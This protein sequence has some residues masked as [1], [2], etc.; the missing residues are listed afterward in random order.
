MTTSSLSAQYDVVVIGAGHAGAEAALAAAGMGSRTLVVTPNLDR[1][2]FMPCNP[3]IGGP[4]KS[5]IVAEIDALGGAMGRVADM[6]AVQARELNTRKGPAVRAVRLQCDKSLYAIAMKETLERQGNLDILQDEAVGLHLDTSGRPRVTGVQ[7][8]HS[9]LI[10]TNATVVTAGTFLRARMIS[11]E[12]ATEGGRAGDSADTRLSSSLLDL[13]LRLKRFKTGTPP[14]LDARS[15]DVSACE[16]QPADNQALWLS[17]DGAEGQITP[18]VLPPAPDGIFAETDLL[19]GRTQLRCFQTWTNESTHELIR[20]NLDRAPMYNGSIEGTGPRYCP[21]IEDKVGRFAHKSSHPIFIEPEGWRSHEV[22]VQGLSTSLPAD[23]QHDVVRSIRGLENARITRYGYAVE[24]DA[25]DATELTRTLETRKVSGLFMAGQ[26]NGTSGYEEAGGQGIIAGANAAARVQGKDPLELSRADGYIG[27]MIDDLTSLP[28]DE[29]YRMLTSRAEYRLILRSDTAD[30]RLSARAHA[31]GLIDDGR[32]A[33]VAEE[34]HQI[35]TILSRLER[36]W[37]GDNPR[38]ADALRA[39][40]LAPASRSMSGL[41]LARRP[42]ARL[43]AVIRSLARLDLWDAP[44]PNDLTLMRT[45]VAI[46]YSSFIEKE[47]REA[48]RH[49]R[50][51]GERLDP[52]MDYGQVTGLRVEATQRLNLTRPLSIGQAARTPGVTPGDISALLV[53]LT[54]SR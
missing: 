16:P 49:R 41:E 6:T 12:D 15:I 20:E 54:R 50:A 4:G 39:E 14:R 1:I 40:G 45:E 3:S 52:N 33:A 22:Y 10:A 9:G 48:S 36:T 23:I 35:D 28:L 21:S 38:H 5:Q 24:Y 53:H 30:A 18:L 8:R 51:A 13:G 34:A 11:G 42:E 19:G 31:L 17:R 2:G 47:E 46:K 44:V 32:Y 7:L 26:V 43:D 29:P 25:L 37:V 27:V